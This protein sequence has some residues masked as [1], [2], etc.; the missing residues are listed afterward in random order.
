ML[1]ETKAGYAASYTYDA[2]GNRLTKTLNG[3]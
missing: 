2:N 3:V 1:S